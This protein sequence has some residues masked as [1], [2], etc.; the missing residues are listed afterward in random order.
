MGSR[1][2]VLQHASGRLAGVC[3]ILGSADAL[4]SLFNPDALAP[5]ITVNVRGRRLGCRL[6]SVTPHCVVYREIAEETV[7]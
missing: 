4:S 2:V 7:Q 3:E 1:R 6:T 5:T